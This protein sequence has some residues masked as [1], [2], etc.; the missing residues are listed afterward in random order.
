MDVTRSVSSAELKERTFRFGIRCI[1]VAEALPA[2]GVGDT[3]GKQLIRCGTSVGANYRA[4]TRSRSRSEFIA[5]LGIV[6]EECDEAI[7]WLEMLAE[8]K[9]VPSERL[10]DLRDEANQILSIIISSIKTAR[11]NARPKRNGGA[12]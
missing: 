6:E 4:A 9:L 2:T 8:L 3:L 12:H 7:F 1:R 10:T 11:Q 5:K